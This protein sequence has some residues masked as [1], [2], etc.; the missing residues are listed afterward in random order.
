M[1]I[2][3]VKEK[4]RQASKAKVKKIQDDICGGIKDL[5]YDKELL[6][7]QQEKRA[8][9]KAEI[10]ALKPLIDEDLV[11]DFISLYLASDVDLNRIEYSFKYAIRLIKGELNY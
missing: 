10:E 9:D 7:K 2:D 5:Y 1:N 4:I 6:K 3:T 11:Q 8:S